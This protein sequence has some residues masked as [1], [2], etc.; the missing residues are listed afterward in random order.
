MG[1]VIELKVKTMLD[2]A[3]RFAVEA[4]SG[5]VCK[6]GKPAILHPLRVMN[7]LSSH[8]EEVMAAAV[9]HDVIEDTGAT[10]EDL[11]MA[12]FPS[13]V[14]E[15]VDLCSRPP[16]GAEARPTY[17]EFIDRICKSG[18]LAAVQVKM[19]DIRDNIARLNELPEEERGILKRYN[20][21]LISLSAAWSEMVWK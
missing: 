17:R 11:Q 8:A 14:V 16:E 20:S 7:A 10:L 2:A 21:A 13:T 4:H 5:Q 12:G 3:I 18:S 19:A 6:V 9:L 1:T 15:T